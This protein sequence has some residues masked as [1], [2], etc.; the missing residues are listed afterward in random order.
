MLILLNSSNKSKKEYHLYNS[1]KSIIDNQKECCILI[2]AVEEYNI[3]VRILED[4]DIKWR[5]GHPAT[6]FES[7]IEQANIDYGSFF[8]AVN[9]S[10]NKFCLEHGVNNDIHFDNYSKQLIINDEKY[11]DRI[12][13]KKRG[14]KLDNTSETK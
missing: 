11:W 4:F 3:I 14:V 2:N 13:G 7:Y 12:Y 9:F 5:S 1:I 6:Y 10:N 8:I